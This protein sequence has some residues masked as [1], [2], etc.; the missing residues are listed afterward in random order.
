ML[1][2]VEASVIQVL[3]SLISIVG[4]FNAATVELQII[5]VFALM[6]TLIR[7]RIKF[8]LNG[9]NVVFMQINTIRVRIWL[10]LRHERHILIRSLAA[11]RSRHSGLKL[12]DQ[13]G[14]CSR[15][16]LRTMPIYFNQAVLRAICTS[17]WIV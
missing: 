14:K 10:R 4:H 12:F 16:K 15:L 9:K 1:I 11:C 17:C 7:N 2:L 5:K 3:L 8:H 13:K 6:S